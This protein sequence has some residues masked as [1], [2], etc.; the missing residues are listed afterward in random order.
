MHYR[1]IWHFVLLVISCLRDSLLLCLPC[2]ASYSLSRAAFH[3]PPRLPA[4]SETLDSRGR[5]RPPPL[6]ICSFHKGWRPRCSSGRVVPCAGSRYIPQ[7]CRCVLIWG[8]CIR[9]CFSA[10]CLPPITPSPPC[11]L[12]RSDHHR[13]LNFAALHYP[14][15]RSPPHRSSYFL[16]CITARQHRTRHSL[17]RRPPALWLVQRPQC[18]GILLT[19]ALDTLPVWEHR[20]N[21]RVVN[22][23]I[24]LKRNLKS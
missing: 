20:I 12:R 19:P 3:A 18:L 23:Y 6:G 21:A 16:W 8:D 9:F 14:A 11:S 4:H 2:F 1:Y 24:H 15:G 10:P 22:V 17:H 7:R 5:C 13:S